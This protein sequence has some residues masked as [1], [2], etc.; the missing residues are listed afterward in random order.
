M[1][2]AKAFFLYSLTII[3]ILVFI[4]I[5]VLYIIHKVREFK[6]DKNREEE[7]KLLDQYVREQLKSKRN[8]QV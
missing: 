6:E 8:E 3:M 1:E 2:S 7:M 4:G 5:S